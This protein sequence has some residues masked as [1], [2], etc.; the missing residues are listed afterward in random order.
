MSRVGGTDPGAASAGAG[1]SPCHLA[2]AGD[3]GVGALC[4]GRGSSR[5]SAE[6][7]GA[8]PDLGGVTG[9]IACQGLNLP[10][11]PPPCSSVTETSPVPSPGAPQRERFPTKGLPA[12]PRVCFVPLG[13]AGQTLCAPARCSS[14]AGINFSAFHFL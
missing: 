13:V 10:R 12:W 6:R 9:D 7:S 1:L 8:V 3:P 11:G 5:S 4:W 14:I 2:A